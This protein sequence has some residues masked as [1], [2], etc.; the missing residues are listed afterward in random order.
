MKIL[1]PLF[2]AWMPIF[3]SAQTASLFQKI[4]DQLLHLQTE[5]E[6]LMPPG[7]RLINLEEDD[8]SL[9][10]FLSIPPKWLKADF[11]EVLYDEWIE[12]FA[13]CISEEGYLRFFL[14]AQ[15]EAG[16]FKPLSDFL[17]HFP[18]TSNEIVKNLDNAP[19]KK[20]KLLRRTERLEGEA[21][22]RGLLTGKTVWLSA[23]HGWQYHKRKKTFK[24]QRH[25]SHGLVEDFVTIETVNYH[26]LKYLYN[27]GANVW[28]VRE[29][30]MNTHEVIIDNDQGK[31][32]YREEGKWIT[33]PTKGYNGRTYRYAIT[34][35]RANA[36]AIYRAAVP[37]S[38]KY[39]VSVHYVSGDNRTVDARYVIH[40]AGGE[41]VVCI[42]QEVHGSTWVY[43]GQFYFEKG[44][45]GKVELINESEEKGQAVIA[46]AVRFG[47]GKG[48]IPDCFY[49]KSS[50]EPRYE[51][52]AKYYAVYQGFPRCMNDVTI[53]P[54]Y[55]EWELSKGTKEER[56]N[57]I[58]LSLHSNAS[59]TPGT[60]GTESYIH[61]Y[62]PIQ[63]SRSLRSAIHD[64][65]VGDLRQAWDRNWKDRGKKAADFGELRGLRTMPGVLLE[66][67]FHDHRQDAKALSSPG[68]RQL[69]ARAIY[70]G[71]VRYFAKKQGRRPVFLP[72]PPTHLLA[73]N[74]KKGEIRLS[75]KV[76]PS[77]GVYG[78][79]ASEYRVY[80]SRNGKGFSKGYYC[81]GTEVTFKDLLPG[82][83]YYFQV[84]AIN[85]GGESLPSSVIA[86][87]TP[88]RGSTEKYLIV[89]GFDRLDRTMAIMDTEYK[90]AYAPIGKHR[91]LFLEQMNNY[92]YIIPHA[93]ALGACNIA[94]DAATNEAV[95]DGALAINRYDGVDWFLGKESVQN[96]TL[97]K[98]EQKL[99][100][101]YLD[102]GGN[103]IISGSE[104]AYELDHKKNG[105]R[106]FREYLKAK[107]VGDNALAG[108]FYAPSSSIFRGIDG[109]FGPDN[110][111][112]YP[113][114][115]P[116]FILPTKGG[117]K[118]L[119]YK[120]GKTAAVV[121]RG[122][123]GLV[124]F[125]F[126]LEM[127]AKETTRL[128]LFRK[129]IAY[130][131]DRP[132]Q[133]E[134][135]RQE[136]DITRFPATFDRNIDLDLSHIPEGKAV[137]NLYDKGGS[138]VYS[139]TW[140]HRGFRKKSI[141]IY[142]LPKAV[143]AYEL[144]LLGRRQKGFILKE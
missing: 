1:L 49:G 99:L 125:A 93:E 129:S 117:K 3:L 118:G 77:G 130:L 24:T 55:A 127:V 36:K 95:R 112:A 48:N 58:Y 57:A 139:K 134:T 27:A 82:T 34:R 12:H 75:W 40:H 51:E 76:P 5:E 44:V 25:N 126:P 143:Y 45:N 128:A 26:L 140:N 17:E 66:M 138:E 13:A 97:D 137:L 120:N 69:N 9:K 122:E 47:G 20:G 50:G 107:Y 80:E 102:G 42:N 132:V 21:Q 23:G 28:T 74:T 53:R 18:I 62:R 4:Q 101:N 142:D 113:V 73:Q 38:G 116:D 63:G 81:K 119:T 105:T 84:T 141:R 16:T 22:P 7:T 67:A 124:H 135:G 92:D 98:V 52:A 54:R 111:H 10:L 133:V 64:E 90:P 65:L 15:N 88:T 33:S 68:F 89:D 19:A 100:S 91:R 108:S 14:L 123:Y 60:S 110:H 104:L 29:R 39:W 144:E 83:T 37:E 71:I 106:F 86:V 85:D 136:Y 35:K 2:L 79:R 41:S 31:P 87:R 59:A 8:Q 131:H 46:D 56:R 11:D 78:H 43:L 115:S 109:K 114:S 72:E 70:K 121:Y 94:F 32:N 103:L 30:D 6:A 61:A 96:Q